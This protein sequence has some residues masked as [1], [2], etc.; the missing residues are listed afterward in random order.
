MSKIPDP[1]ALSARL[2]RGGLTIDIEEIGEPVSTDDRAFIESLG[3][4]SA[5]PEIDAVYKKFDRFALA[6][7]GKVDGKEAQGSIN[8]LPF[9]HSLGR[10]PLRGG[11]EPLEGI[12]WT[13]DTPDEARTL[14]Q[15]MTILETVQGRSQF[16][17]YIVDDGELRLYLVER[18]DVRPLHTDF[19]QT[20]GVLFDYAGAEG[21]RARL[22]HPDWRARIAGDAL[23]QAIG[24]LK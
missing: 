19:A 4:A 21:L 9:S 10:A 8:L 3:F 18:D 2:K 6:W 12:L 20:L 23:L 5:P 14:L 13:A 16:I 17:T 1:A 22:T 15:R 24:A 7:H 11:T